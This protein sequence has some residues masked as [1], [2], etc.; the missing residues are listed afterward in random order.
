MK[1]SHP[2][3]GLVIVTKGSDL[4]NVDLAGSV[5][6]DADLSKSKINDANLT[7][8]NL[9][10]SNLNG[11]RMKQSVL[12][13]ARLF[14]VNLEGASMKNADLTGADLSYANLRSANLRGVDLR[15][16]NLTG[17][18]LRKANLTGA[19]LYGANLNHAQ[20]E[21]TILDCA[22]YYGACFDNVNLTE[23]VVKKEAKLIK[24]SFNYALG[25]RYTNWGKWEDYHD[26]PKFDWGCYGCGEDILSSATSCECGI[27]EEEGNEGVYEWAGECPF[28]YRTPPEL[29][30]I[31]FPASDDD[32]AEFFDGYLHFR[33]NKY[34]SGNFSGES[35][36]GICF[37]R[38][39]GD[40]EEV[41]LTGAN[42]S[43]ADLEESLICL[44]A[45]VGT[46]FRYANL[47]NASF[48]GW[49]DIR[50]ADFSFANLQNCGFNFESDPDEK[51]DGVNF[52]GADLRGSDIYV[53]NETV[54]VSGAKVLR[55]DLEKFSHSHGDLVIYD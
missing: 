11:V 25:N 2:R 54:K 39:H 30:K 21:E 3:Q 32:V 43:G 48:I 31:N 37:G 50:G 38:F 23:S 9:S 5:I 28:F 15:G 16:A 19:S 8:I 47:K 44:Y 55:K 17:A 45:A 42:F 53:N 27:H 49:G 34:L 13:G 12:V 36:N 4:D 46:N 52:S 7:G 35:F 26:A 10:G 6:I 41:E 1:V 22:S 18:D 51:M 40:V 33:T 20:V 24:A 14:E 29:G